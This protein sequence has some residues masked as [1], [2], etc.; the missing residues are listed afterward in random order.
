MK[1]VDF[2]G[3]GNELLQGKIQDKNL[4]WL[5]QWLFKNHLYLRKAQIVRDN[6]KELTEALRESLQNADIVITSGGLG[7]TDDDITKD[8]IADFFNLPLEENANALQVVERQYSEKK[9]SYSDSSAKYQWIP[10]S[11]RAL[12]NKVGYAPGIYLENQNKKIFLLPGVPLEYQVLLED[13]VLPLIV[14]NNHLHK[15]LIYRT[16]KIPEEKLFK[17]L[18]PKLWSELEKLGAVSSLPHVS[19]V[20]VGITIEAKSSQELKN[21]EEQVQAIIDNSQITEYIWNRG[22]ESLP[23]VILKLCQSQNFTIGTAES[24]TGGMISS[25]LTDISGASES[26]LGAFITYS[27]EAK[28][29]QLGVSQDTIDKYNIV[30]TQVALEMARGARKNLGCDFAVA[31]TGLAG[32]GGGSEKI[33]VGTLAVAVVS[34][35]F[36]R[37]EIIHYAGNRLLV[38]D[39][40]TDTALHILR[41]EILKYDKK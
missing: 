18:E 3:I 23:E 37:T 30:S 5:A 27:P 12:Y 35:Q 40:F 21:K 41:E 33:P 2:I 38:K 26:F 31:T 9:R 17:T 15:N 25:K 32:P 36:E 22:P 24:C 19:G 10:K 8:V 6:P 16:W 11:S 7:P 4:H 14:E 28:I 1:I 29:R 34:P 13:Q 39:R 20:D